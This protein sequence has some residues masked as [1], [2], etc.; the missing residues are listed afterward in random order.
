MRGWYEETSGQLLMDPLERF[1]RLQPIKSALDALSV[2][3]PEISVRALNSRAQ[4]DRKF[5]RILIATAL[6]LPELWRIF[7]AGGNAAESQSWQ[8]VCHIVVAI[9]YIVFA[10]DPKRFCCRKNEAVS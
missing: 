4:I 2:R 1:L 9:S 7:R 5:Q 6:D 8:K 10:S 3:D